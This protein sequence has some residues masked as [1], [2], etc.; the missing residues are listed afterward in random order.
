VDSALDQFMIA[1]FDHFGIHLE[2]LTRRTFQLGSAGVFA[3]SFPGLP[4]E[5][6]TVT[7]DRQRALAREDIQFLT[8][9][10][11]LVSGALDLLLGSE[12]GNCSFAKWPDSRT[13]GLYVETVYLLECI[14]PAYL[15]VDRF[16]PPT[17]LRILVD[18]LGND[19]RTAI[20]PETLAGQLRNGD[21]YDLLM[22]S[23]FR[24][25]LLPAL[26]EK[27]RNIASGQLPEIV[28]RA[29]K[30]M[31]AQL[32]HEIARL[33]DLQRV[34]RSVRAEEIDLL[35]QQQRALDQHLA[36][37]RLRLDAIRIIQRG[38]P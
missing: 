25:E 1:I 12:K 9:D 20:S 36:S 15:Q 2:E 24:D 3:D 11:P 18:H 14:A 33:K 7:C 27:T 10:H 37:A 22:Q 38:L 4:A 29:R 16:L 28:S 32:D 21:G 35:V 30:E 26:I 13:A 34:N 23:Q 31:T 19:A 17:P 8:W 5:G 6:L